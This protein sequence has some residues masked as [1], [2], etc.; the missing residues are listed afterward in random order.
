MA[1]IRS[2]R[3]KTLFEIDHLEVS[4]KSD[5]IL[6]SFSFRALAVNLVPM[7]RPGIRIGWD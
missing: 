6:D 4:A 7:E 5:R 3:Y 1:G 2:G